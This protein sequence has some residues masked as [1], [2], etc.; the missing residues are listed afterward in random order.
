MLQDATQDP[1]ESCQD[2]TVQDFVSILLGSN[3][4]N[5]LVKS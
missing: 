4:T 5:H 3:F 2:T 1:T